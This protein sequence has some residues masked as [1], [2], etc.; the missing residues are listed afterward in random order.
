MNNYGYISIYAN[1]DPES[2]PMTVFDREDLAKIV[3]E[4]AH[5]VAEETTSEEYDWEDDSYY[6]G[7]AFVGEVA[8]IVNDAMLAFDRGKTYKDATGFIW[9]FEKEENND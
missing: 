1:G 9:K 8:A 3:L 4:L 5:E 6:D 2:E 7:D